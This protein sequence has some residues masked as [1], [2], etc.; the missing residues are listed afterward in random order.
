MPFLLVILFML[1]GCESMRQFEPVVRPPANLAAICK[2]PVP[3][4]NDTMGAMA[5]A[6][7]ANTAALNDCAERHRGLSEW[8]VEAARSQ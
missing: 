6:L 2:A 1:S 5:D 7:I 8:I 4:K 3:L